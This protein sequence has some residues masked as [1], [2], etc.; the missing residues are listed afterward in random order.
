[1]AGKGQEGPQSAPGASGGFRPGRSSSGRLL[2]VPL[3]PS[4]LKLDRCGRQGIRPA[5]ESAAVQR[6][7]Q[8]HAAAERQWYADLERE[9]EE[10]E[11]SDPDVAAAAAL[12]ESVKAKLLKGGR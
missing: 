8:V 12:L 1:M 4:D 2:Q 10:L 7:Q 6:G 5:P 9:L 3:R 11:A